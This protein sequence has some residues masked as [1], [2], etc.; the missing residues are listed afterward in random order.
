MSQEAS[1][2]SVVCCSFS[3]T[4]TVVLFRPTHMI[5]PLLLPPSIRFFVTFRAGGGTVA[6]R[7]YGAAPV[8]VT[9]T[10]TSDLQHGMKGIIADW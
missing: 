8:T 9:D 4:S 10:Q 2:S 7:W 3:F 5:T 6:S 1:A